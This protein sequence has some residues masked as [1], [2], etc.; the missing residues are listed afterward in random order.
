MNHNEVAEDK[1]PA[2]VSPS[3]SAR[4][5]QIVSGAM[6]RQWRPALGLRH[7]PRSPRALT[8]HPGDVVRYDGTDFSLLFDASANGIPNGEITDAVAA[9]GSN[10]LLL[11][12][13]VPVA[14]GSIIARH[15]DVVRFHD[16]VFSIFFDGS[17]AGVLPGLDLDALYCIQSNG[18]LLMSFDGSGV[19]GGVPF[20]DE[21]VL[22]YTPG[23]GTWELAYDGQSAHAGWF[24]ADLQALAAT[25][26][27]PR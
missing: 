3:V 19:L 8:V 4:S 12:F 7:R 18:H 26:E 14:L 25:T 9:I 6:P 21:D 15:S 5:I 24:G 20:D 22:E 27:P 10:D 11:S 1:P 2:P 16:G 23:P 13:D 17:A